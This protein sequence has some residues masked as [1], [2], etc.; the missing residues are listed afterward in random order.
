MIRAKFSVIGLGLRSR[1]VRV[2]FVDT[3]CVITSIVCARPCIA[4]LLL[5]HIY[6][7]TI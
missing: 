6:P 1:R 7:H 5:M 2:S 3:R 4:T